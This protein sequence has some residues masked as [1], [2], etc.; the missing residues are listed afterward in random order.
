[1]WVSGSL[2]HVCVCVYVYIDIYIYIYTYMY[3]CVCVSLSMC[4]WL[5]VALYVVGCRSVFFGCYSYQ[6]WLWLFGGCPLSLSLFFLSG[7]CALASESVYFVYVRMNEGGRKFMLFRLLCLLDV[8]AVSEVRR[9]CL[10][11]LCVVS[12]VSSWHACTCERV[13]HCLGCSLAC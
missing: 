6:L 8:L 4:V 7:R 11:T 12:F 5:A 9:S 1:V 3:V 2:F 10:F 13:L